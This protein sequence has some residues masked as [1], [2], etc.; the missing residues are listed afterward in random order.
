M[1]L[2]ELPIAGKPSV[3]IPSPYVAENHQ[4]HN[5]MTLVEQGAAL[6]IEEKDLTGDALWEAICSIT[7]DAHKMEEM[8]ANVRRLAIPDAQ[9]RIYRV[10][11]DELK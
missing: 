11:C 9:E 2:S 4:Y 6:C 10:I 7:G 1:T 5:A 8:A 3:L